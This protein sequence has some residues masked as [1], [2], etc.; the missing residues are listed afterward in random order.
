MSGGLVAL[1]NRR[2][3]L[4]YDFRFHAGP[5]SGKSAQDHSPDIVSTRNSNPIRRYSPQA[6]KLA[7]TVGIK[8]RRTIQEKKCQM[9]PRA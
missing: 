7:E 2:F 5:F 3:L 8:A 1:R 4:G 9:F 6:Q